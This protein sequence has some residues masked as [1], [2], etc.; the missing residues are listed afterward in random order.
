MTQQPAPIWCIDDFLTDKDLSNRDLRRISRI[1]GLRFESV[2]ITAQ[3]SRE[4]A[5]ISRGQVERETE[6]NE[7][8]TELGVEYRSERAKIAKEIEEN[9][10]TDELS[11]PNDW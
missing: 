2:W 8:E 10:H 9:R 3:A 11:N 6:I 7:K 1:L 4:E 5:G